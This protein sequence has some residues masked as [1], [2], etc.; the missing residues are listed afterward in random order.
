MAFQR[1]ETKAPGKNALHLDVHVTDDSEVEPVVERALA[2][3]GRVLR[4]VQQDDAEWVV[5]LDPENNQ[6]CVVAVVPSQGK[7]PP[8]RCDR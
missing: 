8:S 7:G 6:F 2:L 3:G 4:R 5:L 1:V